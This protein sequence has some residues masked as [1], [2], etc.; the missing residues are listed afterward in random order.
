MTDSAL[1]RRKCHLTA[2]HYCLLPA[3]M[4]LPPHTPFTTMGTAF[5]QIMTST[6]RGVLST[7][8]LGGKNDQ[9]S[10]IR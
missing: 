2:R 7:G 9:T 6:G 4:T 3:R 5:L 8:S 10:R 1:W